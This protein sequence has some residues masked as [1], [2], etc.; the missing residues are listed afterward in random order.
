MEETVAPCDEKT[1]TAPVDPMVD[2]GQAREELLAEVQRLQ[3]RVTDLEQAE[4][5]RRQAEGMFEALLEAAPDALVIINQDGRMVLVNSETERMF[6]YQREELLGQPVEVL[7]PERV[8]P[9]HV[10]HRNRYFAEP[11]ARP[12]GLN[13]ELHGQRKNGREFPVEISLSPLQTSSGL[14][15]T[16]TIRDI[17]QRRRSESELRRAEARYR[18]LVEQIP[19]VTFMAALDEGQ[20]ELY[21]SPQIESL[22]GFT[23]KEW[24]ENPVLWHT[25]L[26]PED[27]ERWNHEFCPTVTSGMPFRSIYRFVAR[28]GRIVWIHGEA[29]V[30]RDES[31]QP[32]FLQGVAFDITSMKQAE[33]ELKK[34]NQTLEQ[35][36]ADRTREAEER[37]Q[38]LAQSNAELEQ[39]A[40]VA[41]HD[42]QEP[43]RAVASFAKLLAR[44]YPDQL[45][46][47][48][49]D[50]ISRIVNGAVRMQTLITDLLAY[51]RVGRQGRPFAPTDCAAVLATV[52]GNLRVAIEESGAQVTADLLPLVTA[53][54]TELIQ[55]LQNL[56][57]NAL[58]FRGE[59]PPLVHVGCA[60]KDGA[61]VF[62]V[63]DNGIGIDQKYMD[64]I[65]LIFQRLHTRTR[66]PGT[67]IGLA[68]CKKI[69]ERHGGR[70][71]VEG[72]LGKGSTF[73][74]TLPRSLP[75]N[76]SVP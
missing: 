16:A 1:E 24:L 56:I 33:D 75:E 8:R 12:M 3:E 13:L 25:Q 58:K 2:R 21:V 49:Q 51:S 17:S 62:A 74:F 76:E 11:H 18:S 19:A 72:E 32:L 5:Q 64:R 14:L 39:F 46:E 10:A 34:L 7:V 37:A 73:C 55:L 23:Q 48:A 68:I 35:R 69:V 60:Q 40:Y 50:Y 65:F 27:Q 53:D 43:L 20:S 42:L 15:V 36:I 67:G 41:S 54:E 44:K 47:T 52:C 26:H 28:D 9:G 31:G 38:Q 66:Y 61:W 59:Q 57:G 30:A 4:T 70:I 71:W 63:Q 6:G 22:L 45:D 29:K